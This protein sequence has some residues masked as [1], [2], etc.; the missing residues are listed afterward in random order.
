MEGP[1]IG[2]QRKRLEPA[3]E[4]SEKN[5]AELGFTLLDSVYFPLSELPKIQTW[6]L[7]SGN[8]Y[9]AIALCSEDDPE[10][11][12]FLKKEVS[13]FANALIMGSENKVET[14]LEGEI[15]KG[16]AE[17]GLHTKNS[18]SWEPALLELRLLRGGEPNDLICLLLAY[19]SKDNET[20]SASNNH[21]EDYYSKQDDETFEELEWEVKRVKP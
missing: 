3:K 18:L 13:G 20:N 8:S 16:H 19:K 7:H 4:R 17:L 21:P 10:L 11:Q 6:N 14:I 9:H 2:H 5:L 15:E 12:L 1:V